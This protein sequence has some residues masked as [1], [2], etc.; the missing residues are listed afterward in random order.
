MITKKQVQEVFSSVSKKYDF[1][2]NLVTLRKIDQWQRD[3]LD[4]LPYEG[5]RLDVG[6]GTGEVL[7]KSQ[8]KG[9]RV[10]IDLSL[11][12]LKV[13]RSK[14]KACKFL[15][16]DGENMPFK[17]GSF[18]SISLSLVYRHLLNRKAFLKEAKRV[19]REEGCIAILDI[20]KFFL[21]PLLVFFMKYPLKPLGLLLFGGEKWEFFIH[22]LENSLGVEEVKGELREEGFYVAEVQRRLFGLVYLILAKKG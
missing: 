16:A 5:N 20:N 7:L 4:M 6:T 3:L 12:M 11:E 1:F 9:I 21:T 13:A 19:L 10:G 14:C 15:V 22:S 17:D 8:N 18:S 2:L